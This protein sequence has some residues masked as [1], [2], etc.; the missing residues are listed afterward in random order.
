MQIRRKQM[1]MIRTHGNFMVCQ[2]IVASPHFFLEEGADH[3]DH[4]GATV[5]VHGFVERPLTFACDLTKMSK[6]NARSE[7]TN[8]R[9]K[10]VVCS[11]AVGAYAESKPVRWCVNAMQNVTSIVTASYGLSSAI[12]RLT[13]RDLG[14]A[15][16]LYDE[17]A[18]YNAVRDRLWGTGDYAVHQPGR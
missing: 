6:V 8:H 17:T 2:T 9:Q 3:S 18:Y 16:P 11:S 4:I 1:P 15:V 12:G 10:I 14:L 7:F 5:E 13:A